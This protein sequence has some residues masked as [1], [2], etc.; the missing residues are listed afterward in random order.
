MNIMDV[1]K[2]IDAVASVS[3]ENAAELRKYQRG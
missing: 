2:S 1:R 3:K